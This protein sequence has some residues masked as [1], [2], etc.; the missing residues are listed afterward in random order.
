[1]GPDLAGER[2]AFSDLVLDLQR[3]AEGA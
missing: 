2:I 3:L 1:V